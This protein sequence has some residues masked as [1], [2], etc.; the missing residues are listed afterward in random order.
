MHGVVWLEVSMLVLE[1]ED[2]GTV[3][4]SY[5]GYP[6]PSSDSSSPRFQMFV[7]GF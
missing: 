1:A 3:V 5:K 7:P 2:E 4:Q 6:A